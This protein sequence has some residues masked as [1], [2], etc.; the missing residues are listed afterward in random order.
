VAEQLEQAKFFQILSDTA[1]GIDRC[2]QAL[3]SSF[4]PPHRIAVQDGRIVFRHGEKDD[5]LLSFLKLVKIAS[6]HNA[7]MILMREGYV[8]EGYALC[9]MIDEAGEDI[10]FMAK[11]LGND[12]QPSADQRRFI[13]EFFQEEFTG[14]DLVTSHQ[15]RDRVPRRKVRAANSR[16]TEGNS[17]HNPS[18]DLQ[19]TST[20]SEKY[21]R[22]GS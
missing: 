21:F 19:A 6:H 1:V 13:E 17:S 9:R 3:A 15:S 20:P 16:L 18:R 14:P 5:L 8:Q 7:A 10:F 22:I 12:G 2:V 11:P 4:P